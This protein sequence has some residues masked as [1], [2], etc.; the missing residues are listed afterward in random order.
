[1]SYKQ[2]FE[3]QI[4]WFP[5]HHVWGFGEG[6]GEELRFQSREDQELSTLATG[7]NSSSRWVVITRPWI[8]RRGSWGTITK[9]SLCHFAQGTTQ[10][11]TN[12]VNG[13]KNDNGFVQSYDK[14]YT[15][16]F[17]RLWP[18]L[19]DKRDLGRIH[20]KG[21]RCGDRL[22]SKTGWYQNLTHTTTRWIWGSRITIK[23]FF[24]YWLI[25]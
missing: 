3:N 6:G 11:D 12:F 16:V 17:T 24:G 20:K 10:S 14:T 21:C 1:M 15:L 7:T 13:A 2:S 5:Q 4:T 9:R 19:P 25:W 18:V 8:M 23:L 22:R